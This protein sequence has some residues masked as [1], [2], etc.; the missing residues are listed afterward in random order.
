MIKL[1][2]IVKL[3]DEEIAY[4]EQ[5]MGRDIFDFKSENHELARSIRTK[6]NTSLHF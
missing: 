2:K 4:L 6:F 1:A 5:K 3:E